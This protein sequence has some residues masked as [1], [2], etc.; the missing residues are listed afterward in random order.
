MPYW[1]IW[2][3]WRGQNEGREREEMC[4]KERS[5]DVS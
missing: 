2:S 5:A 4:D 3:D 1:G